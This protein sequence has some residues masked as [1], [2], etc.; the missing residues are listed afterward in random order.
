MYRYGLLKPVRVADAEDT[1]RLLLGPSTL[2]IEVTEAELAVRCGL[3][4]IDPQHGASASPETAI[5]AC[6]TVELPPPG[7]LLVTIR[8]DADAFGAMALL[9]AR[10]DGCVPTD[11]MVER[12][13]EIARM[14]SFAHGP[15]PGV[16]PLPSTVEAMANGV[17]GSAKLT[18]LA[19]ATADGAVDT[20]ARVNLMRRW[21]ETGALPQS[22]VD[23]VCS[24]CAN[25][26]NGLRSGE[27]RVSTVSNGQI[28]LV[29]G[30]QPAALRLGY[31]L[32]PV[33]IALNPANRLGD[34]AP[35]RKFTVCQYQEGYVAL[36][37]AAAD[38]ASR[39]PGW[40]GSPTIIG[41]PQGVGSTLSIDAVVAVVASWLLAAPDES[42]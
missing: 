34:G 26:V 37:Q 33:V 17:G 8:A 36:R 19:A 4:N 16:R 15:W 28:A 25:L 40:G 20:A 7:S 27:I 21:L 5:E 18:A 30:K 35:H 10:A 32:A 29:E 39:E 22:L 11:A 12:I 2:G 13:G 41:S 31:F 23:G 24:R 38:L 14:D 6:L 1:N 42:G 9:T 3:G